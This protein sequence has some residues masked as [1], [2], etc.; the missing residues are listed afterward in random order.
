VAHPG[1]AIVSPAAS[2]VL[3]LSIITARDVPM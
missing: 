2:T 1:V 3:P